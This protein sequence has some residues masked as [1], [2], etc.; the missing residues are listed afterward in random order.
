M[1]SNERASVQRWPTG[2]RKE[3]RSNA[4]SDAKQRNKATVTMM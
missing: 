4:L 3:I 2:K 1:F